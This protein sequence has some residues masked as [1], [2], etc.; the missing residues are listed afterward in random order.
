MAVQPAADGG[1]RLELRLSRLSASRIDQALQRLR[2]EPGV[3]EAEV[4]A[5][6]ARGARGLVG[7]LEHPAGVARP[8]A[9]IEFQQ[10]LGRGDPALRHL[11]QGLEEDSLVQHP[12][13][14]PSAGL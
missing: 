12:A 8:R 6:R 5:R 3:L 1:Q 11:F 10:P 7:Q 4:S 2:R 13:I 9:V 14:E